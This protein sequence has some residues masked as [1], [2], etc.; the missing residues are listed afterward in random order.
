MAAISL[1]AHFDGKTIL[2]DE[3]YELPHDAQLLVTVLTAATAQPEIGGWAELSTNSLA[4]AYGDNE[5]EYSA[6]DVVP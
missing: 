6:S 2:L 4:R 1:R 3:P 5:P